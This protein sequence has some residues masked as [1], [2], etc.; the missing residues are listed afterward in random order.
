MRAE[1]NNTEKTKQNKKKKQKQKQKKNRKNKTVEGNNET[2][3]W[4]FKIINK[5]DQALDS[6][7]NEKRENLN[8]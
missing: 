7:I 2:K 6:L 5:M 1:I 8:K 3:S 4:F